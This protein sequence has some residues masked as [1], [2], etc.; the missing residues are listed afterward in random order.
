M[1]TLDPGT[2][3]AGKFRIERVLDVGAWESSW[4]LTTCTWAFGGD[5]A[6]ETRRIGARG[7]RSEVRVEFKANMSRVYSM[8]G[9]SI[10]AN[11]IW[12]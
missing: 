11:P 10:R 4:L 12:S 1:T 8:W 9:H 5:Q 2:V 6:I 3:V 7:Y